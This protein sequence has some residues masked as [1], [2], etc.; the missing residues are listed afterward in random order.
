MRSLGAIVLF[1]AGI[2]VAL[3]ITGVYAVVSFAVSQRTREFGIQMVLGATRQ[4][5][6]RSVLLRGTRQIAAGLLFGMAM[7][8]PAA[9]GLAL[10]MKKTPLPLKTFDPSV[11]AISAVILCVV[12]LGAMCLPALRATEVD[13]IQAIRDQ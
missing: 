5:I 10:L 8:G 6:F 9:W 11:Y 1:M 12:G 13:P 2:A 4:G 7:A 3:A